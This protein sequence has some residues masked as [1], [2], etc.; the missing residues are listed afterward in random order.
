M[1]V[2]EDILFGVKKRFSKEAVIESSS[3]T[4]KR[5][6]RPDFKELVATYRE[7]IFHY[8]LSMVHDWDDALDLTQECFLKAY[9]FY[10][11][12]R[13]EG[14]IRSW[15]YKIALNTTRNYYKHKEVEKRAKER[16]GQ[17]DFLYLRETP[18][19]K[20]L[21]KELKNKIELHLNELPSLQRDI[22]LLRLNSSLTYSEIAKILDTSEESA[23]VSFHY[24]IKRLR[25]MLEEDGLV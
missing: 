7:E 3:S 18:Y 25:K 24:G 11:S 23:R 8:I 13:G 17:D 6:E 15:L 19:Q 4:K 22:L 9:R 1:K 21:L 20:T 14:T 5:F 2:L 16:L 10:D 12:Y